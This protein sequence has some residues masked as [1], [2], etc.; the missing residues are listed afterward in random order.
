MKIGN[1]YI[2]RVGAV[3]R[4]QDTG[5]DLYMLDNVNFTV[6]SETDFQCLDAIVRC[7][8]C[9][10]NP[11]TSNKTTAEVVHGTAEHCWK[12]AASWHNYCPFGKRRDDEN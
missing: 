5:E 1:E 7:L 2:V 12:F 10:H 3:L 9:I 6:L 11:Y 8:D 4:D